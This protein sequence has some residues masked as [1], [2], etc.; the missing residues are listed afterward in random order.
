MSKSDILK[1]VKYLLTALLG[2]AASYL[3]SSCT[4]G[5]VVGSHQTQKQYQEITT[6][7][8]STHFTPTLQI[9]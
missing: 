9:K 1:F 2:A 5:M 7:S 4:M 8:D 3:S 6:K